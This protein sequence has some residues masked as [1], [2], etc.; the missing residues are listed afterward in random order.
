MQVA[1]KEK[2][3]V[4]G[5]RLNFTSSESGTAPCHGSMPLVPMTGSEGQIHL[6]TPSPCIWALSAAKAEVLAHSGRLL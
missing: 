5:R 6:S 1:W 4:G 3:D 2:E